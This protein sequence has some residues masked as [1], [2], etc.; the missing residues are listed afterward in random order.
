MQN[1]DS[2]GIQF[3]TSIF[4]SAGGGDVGLQIA[5]SPKVLSYSLAQTIYLFIWIFIFVG[6]NQLVSKLFNQ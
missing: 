5:R 4:T 2:K 1:V 6:S 3:L